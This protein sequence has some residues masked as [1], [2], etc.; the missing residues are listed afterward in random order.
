VTDCG[1]FSYWN[2]C[3]KILQASSFSGISFFIPLK[4]MKRAELLFVLFSSITGCVKQCH[5][6]YNACQ[7]AR[8]DLK[9]IV[10]DGETVLQHAFQR[11]G[12]LLS[13]YP[14]PQNPTEESFPVSTEL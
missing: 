2:E 6:K 10:C 12:I 5:G 13:G 14:D 1:S 4:I 8:A 9:A 3:N 7:S 11:D